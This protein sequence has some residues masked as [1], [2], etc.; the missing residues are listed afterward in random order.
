M[1]ETYFST[2]A[3]NIITCHDR[4]KCARILLGEMPV[5]E[6]GRGSTGMLREPSDQDTN[7][8]LSEGE[9]RRS[10][11]PRLWGSLREVQKRRPVSSRNRPALAC[12]LC[13]VTSWGQPWKPG[14]DRNAG[15]DLRAQQLGPL[16]VT[17]PAGGALWGTCLWWPQILNRGCYP[18][19]HPP[20]DDSFIHQYLLLRSYVPRLT[21]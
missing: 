2:N 10:I 12:L 5:R 7:S 1:L 21:S 13:S 6:E 18:L 19:S 9:G 8:T 14:Q 16:S 15:T 4:I 17:L 20:P 3:L 11:L